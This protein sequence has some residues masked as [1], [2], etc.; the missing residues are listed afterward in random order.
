MVKMLQIVRSAS[1]MLNE[2]I[3]KLYQ[4]SRPLPLLTGN[5]NT[6]QREAE[7]KQSV[8]EISNESEQLQAKIARRE[9]GEATEEEQAVLAD[10]TTKAELRQ[11]Q[12]EELETGCMR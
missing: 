8:A 12:L 5:K 11:Q 9:G 7:L 4:R 6:T 1:E 2:H 3:L 10:L